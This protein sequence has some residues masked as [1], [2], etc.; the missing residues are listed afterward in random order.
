MTETIP[1]SSITKD[2][3]LQMRVAV[4]EAAVTDYAD[5][6]R[7]T[8]V[9]E[10]VPLPPIIVFREGKK[11]WLADGFHRHEGHVRAGATEIQADVRDG[12]K[13]DAILFSVGANAHHGLRRTND[14]KR[15]AVGVLLAD[16]EWAKWS[17]REI[18]RRAGVS[19]Q[20][21]STM[22]GEAS[23]NG[24]QMATERTVERNGQTYQQNTAN[25]GK[26]RHA[27]REARQ[28]EDAQRQADREA[29][30][31]QLPAE[32]RERMSAADVAKAQRTADAG[33]T[34]GLPPED[35]IAELKAEV[36]SLKVELAAASARIFDLTRFEAMEA[37]YKA[38][39]FEAVIA[40]ERATVETW[41]AKYHAENKEKVAAQKEAKR[42]RQTKPSNDEPV[43]TDWEVV[44]AAS[45]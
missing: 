7:S 14:D 8:P 42:L 22:R 28:A 5:V 37:D 34:V 40:A 43:V 11:L 33:E 32:V 20:F 9:G 21:V 45:R 23:V 30:V 12:T 3:A 2:S 27:E 39:G 25:I 1:L 41:K 26:D 19:N 6:I 13:R 44:R 24:G 29:L 17:D 38:G 4:N 31:A 35:R 10:P 15:K 18:A 16:P 36:E